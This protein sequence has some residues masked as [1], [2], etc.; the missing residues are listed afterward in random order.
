M[1]EWIFWMINPDEMITI[2][3]IAANIITSSERNKMI[4]PNQF[5]CVGVSKEA[6]KGISL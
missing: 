4:S 3:K 1:P 6:D 2:R 5:V